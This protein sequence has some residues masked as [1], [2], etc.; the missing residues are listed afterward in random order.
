VQ[1]RLLHR[2]V[3]DGVEPL[4]LE[5]AVDD[6]ERLVH[7]LHLLARLRPVHAKR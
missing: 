3:A 6:L 5:Q 7:Q 1:V 2:E 4:A